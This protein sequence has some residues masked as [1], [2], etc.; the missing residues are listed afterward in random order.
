MAIRM[1]ARG[2]LDSKMNIP[3]NERFIL[4]HRL[5]IGIR[6]TVETPSHPDAQA[7]NTTGVQIP[8]TNTKSRGVGGGTLWYVHPDSAV[9]VRN[10]LSRW[11]MGFSSLTRMGW[12][13][14]NNVRSPSV[15]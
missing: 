1:S 13:L 9:R 15:L 5:T 12:E 11:I 7:A 10:D 2:R 3:V 6:M 14:T 4:S 8:S